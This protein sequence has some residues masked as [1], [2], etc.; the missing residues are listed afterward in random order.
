MANGL[1]SFIAGM[2]SGY[3]TAQQRNRDQAR[4]DKQDAWQTE[5]QDW[6]RQEQQQ[7]QS[8]QR[9]LADASA[10]RE[11]QAGSVL[12]GGQTQ[13]FYKDPAQVTPQMQD[14]RRIEAE[15]RAELPGAKPI[16]LATGQV[17]PGY[18]T[19]GKMGL[20]S[21]ITK[22]KPDAQAL[23][24]PQAK[25]ERQAAAYDAAGQPEKSAQLRESNITQQ[26]HEMALAD[27]NWSRK[28]GAAMM[29]PGDT[30]LSGLTKLFSESEFGPMAGKQIKDVPSKDGKSVVMHLVNPDGTLTPT[31]M[32]FSND[33]T[34][35]TQA[36]YILDKSVTPEHRYTN[37]VAEKK[38]GR[39]ADKDAAAFEETK[40]HNSATEANGAVTAR[41]AETRANKTGT[42]SAS[43]GLSS[44]KLEITRAREKRLDIKDRIST[45]LKK[46]DNRLISREAA[47]DQIKELEAQQKKY[48]QIIESGTPQSSAAPAPGLATPRVKAPTQPVAAQANYSNLWK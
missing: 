31:A 24:S 25:S 6:Q 4:Q 21:M 5:Q 42:S 7:K 10:P 48:D 2:G 37:Y 40:R 11:V 33:Q 46:S 20:G 26:A 19:T 1:A 43:G 13:E 9:G 17:T 41:A 8:L 23:N 30:A 35:V 22:D 12:D 45:V 34:G 27:K 39:Q 18:G 14:D 47:A 28:I 15:M 29:T 32:Q 44:E 16:G 38:A 3:L 36:G